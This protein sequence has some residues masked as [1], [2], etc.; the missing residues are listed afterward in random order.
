[1]PSNWRS[2]VRELPSRTDENEE[3]ST[4][5][6]DNNKAVFIIAHDSASSV[7][8]AHQANQEEQHPK[9]TDHSQQTQQKNCNAGLSSVYALAE[10]CCPADPPLS[11]LTVSFTE[12][13]THYHGQGQMQSAFRDADYFSSLSSPIREGL[14]ISLRTWFL[15]FW[16][17]GHQY[18]LGT[19]TLHV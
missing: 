8:K 6:H 1:M 7:P 17:M 15:L 18:L 16:T 10:R 14:E 9:E 19:P 5:P 2:P 11:C 13:T 12:S 4:P 3:H